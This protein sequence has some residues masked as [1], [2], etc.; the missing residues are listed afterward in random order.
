MAPQIENPNEEKI[1]AGNH[2][3]Q[4]T[5]WGVL[6]GKQAPQVFVKTTIGLTWFGSLSERALNITLKS[7]VTMG[8]MGDDLSEL[9]KNQ[10]NALDKN[11]DLELVVEYETYNGETRPKIKWVND[12][13]GGFKNQMD[14]GT[15]VKALSGLKVKGDLMKIRQE[16]GI[17]VNQV[18]QTF[19][20]ANFDAD[21][22][23]PF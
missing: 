20:G 1:K 7:L 16:K 11:K 21:N 6:E 4:V 19:G 8:F 3:G 22:D 5:A 18:S 23:I 17:T 9:V 13:G 15:A 10:E 14:S 2:I 12:L